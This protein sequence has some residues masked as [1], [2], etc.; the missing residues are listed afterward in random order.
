MSVATTTAKTLST[1]ATSSVN[2]TN[3]TSS[4][5]ETTSSTNGATN[6]LMSNY[7]MFLNLLT[8]Q[9]KVQNPLEPMD[10]DKF[11][12]QL[13]Q[14]SAVEQQMKTND[15]LQAILASMVSNTAL[16][17]VNYIGKTVTATS[18]TT[19]VDSN[20]GSWKFTAGAASKEATITVRN[21]AGAVVYTGKQEIK[22]GE[23]EFKW[24]GKA[25]DGS[26]VPEGDYSITVD[27]KD[28]KGSAVSI[29]TKVSGTVTAIDTT[30]AE[31]YLKI[32]GVMVPLSRLISIGS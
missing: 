20:G 11:T 23:Q 14:Y 6:A 17:L 18:D 4:A 8:T 22:S 12:D 32:N 19:H 26:T 28:D 30:G 3:T 25:S 1:N 7:S 10:A 15:N 24:D 2:T 9:L 13:V 31:P 27:A 29:S 21:A 5:T 16:S